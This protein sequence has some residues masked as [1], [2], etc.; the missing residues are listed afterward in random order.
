VI[1]KYLMTAPSGNS[2]FCFFVSMFPSVSPRG[3]LRILGK[4]NSPF[5][6]RAVNKCFVILLDSKIIK[7]LRKHH[8]LD[9]CGC[10]AC[11]A[12]VSSNRKTYLCW[13]VKQCQVTAVRVFTIPV[14]VL[15]GKIVI[16]I[17][18]VRG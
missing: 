12:M 6:E 8:L 10:C 7:K 14:R 11:S 2:E 16:V 17:C 3:T 18:S 1:N 15:S 9:V 5:P 4:Q 13:E